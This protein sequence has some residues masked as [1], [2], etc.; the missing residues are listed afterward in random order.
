MS[1]N[2]PK[3]I[4]AARQRE[5]AH[6]RSRLQ[7]SWTADNAHELEATPWIKGVKLPNIPARVGYRQKWIRVALFKEDDSRNV[8]SKYRM[9]YRPRHPDTVPVGMYVPLVGGGEWAGCIG[10][11]GSV[12][13][14]IPESRAQQI[15]QGNRRVSD[16]NTQGIADVLNQSATDPRMPVEQERT[17]RSRAV[18]VAPE[19]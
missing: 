7:D 12:L 3:T 4:R 6:G 8:E 17:S 10:V 19:E 15:E 1:A 18:R 2:E 11:E 9:G 5:P 16:Q 14:E 13:M